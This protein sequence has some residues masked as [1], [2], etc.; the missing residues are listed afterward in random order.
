MA[1][2]HNSLILRPLTP[3]PLKPDGLSCRKY[4]WNRAGPDSSPSHSRRGSLG[5]ICEDPSAPRRTWP[6][7]NGPRIHSDH[8][9]IRLLC[10]IHFHPYGS[11]SDRRQRLS[12]EPSRSLP[13][14]VSARDLLWLPSHQD[15]TQESP[16]I[17]P[18]GRSCT[19]SMKMSKRAMMSITR[20]STGSCVRLIHTLWDYVGF[21]PHF[22]A[23]VPYGLFRSNGTFRI[24]VAIYYKLVVQ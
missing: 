20:S 5:P 4:Y 22:H 6:A 21:H 11:A 7:E 17:L 19:I 16:P 14:A 10:Q 1:P 3:K 8:S 18:Y 24:M 2:T 12:T 15:I 23:I 9:P 13:V